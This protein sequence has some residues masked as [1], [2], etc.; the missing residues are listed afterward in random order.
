MRTCTFCQFALPHKSPPP[1]LRRSTPLPPAAAAAAA[2][3]GVGH[4]LRPMVQKVISTC[5]PP[6][7]PPPR[8]PR[9]DL[10]THSPTSNKMSVWG[11]CVVIFYV[12]ATVQPQRCCHN[13]GFRAQVL[14]VIAGRK[15]DLENS[16]CT[17]GKGRQLRRFA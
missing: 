11:M 10:W 2:A 5:P 12:T 15:K 6:P 17:F 14:T 7:P 3:S 16:S 13:D 9:S 8:S 4:K 1:L